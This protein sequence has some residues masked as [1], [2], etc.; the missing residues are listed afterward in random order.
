MLGRAGLCWPRCIATPIRGRAW[1]ARA[2]ILPPSTGPAAAAGRGI[3]GHGVA[4]Q[5]GRHPA[6]PGSSAPR[7]RG[8]TWR[9]RFLPIRQRAGGRRLMAGAMP[10]PLGARCCLLRYRGR[11]KESA[12]SAA[13]LL[14][15]PGPEAATADTMI[16]AQD[17]TKI[18]RMKAGLFGPA[19]EIRALDG[20]SLSVRRGETVALVGESGSGKSTLARI[21]LGLVE[22]SAGTVRLQGQPILG[23]ADADR[24]RLV[25]P[26]FQDPYS[27]LNPRR[28]VAEIIARPLHLRGEDRASQMSRAREMMEVVRLP[29][30][31]LHSYPTHLSGG[32]RQRVAIARAMVNRPEV[33]ICDEPTSALDV[34]VQAQIL[35]LL[36]DLQAEFGLRRSHHHDMAVVTSWAT[37]V[38]VLLKGRLVERPC[39]D[40]LD[41]LEG[42]LKPGRSGRR[43][44]V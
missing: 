29:T 8:P 12:A 11:G 17:V 27:S 6:G 36:S 32:Q 21:L 3:P 2:G 15:E 26:I 24:A 35:N 23:L 19:R 40:V 10:G 20:V 7:L 39:V 33:L 1:L 18:Y 16:E 9:P 25:Q 14:S 22:P 30:R 44:R 42:R 13:A 34:S 4:A 28:T 5:D 41:R 38:A 37:R 31:L 43:R